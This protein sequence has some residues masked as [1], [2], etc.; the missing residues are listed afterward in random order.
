MD[1]RVWRWREKVI[2]EV[3]EYKCIGY[4][5]QRNGGQEVREG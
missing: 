1:R 4:T 3:K 2:E 5:L